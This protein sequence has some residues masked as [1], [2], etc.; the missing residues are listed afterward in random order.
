MPVPVIHDLPSPALPS[1]LSVS[2]EKTVG[3]NPG[4]GKA[5]QHAE[6]GAGRDHRAGNFKGLWT[7]GYQ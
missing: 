3:R 4:S 6:T 2:E 1:H 5:D 7:I